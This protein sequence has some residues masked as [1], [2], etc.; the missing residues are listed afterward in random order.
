M[1]LPLIIF[2]LISILLFNV[3]PSEDIYIE[4]PQKKF[5]QNWCICKGSQTAY[6]VH[7]SHHCQGENSSYHTGHSDEEI[8]KSKD[9]KSINK[10]WI[11]GEVN[12]ASLDKNGEA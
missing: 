9:V 4:V 1:K 3:S 11:Y 12:C 8:M 5:T 7:T 2:L 6:T 10:M